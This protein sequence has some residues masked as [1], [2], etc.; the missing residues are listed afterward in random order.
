MSIPAKDPSF[1]ME[2][3]NAAGEKFLEAALGY[4][5]AAHKAGISGAII[6]LKAEDGGTAFYTRGE[7]KSAMLQNIDRLGPTVQ[8]GAMKDD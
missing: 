6:W 3:L 7:Y 8:F 5:E 2:E 1:T 4:W